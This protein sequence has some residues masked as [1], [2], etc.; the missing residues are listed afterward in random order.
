MDTDYIFG[1]DICE[2]WSWGKTHVFN[3]G[4]MHASHI[5]RG[6]ITGTGICSCMTFFN[7]EV[8][9]A[10]GWKDRLLAKA[11]TYLN[12]KDAEP[13]SNMGQVWYKLKG[14]QE[15]N[16]AMAKAFPE[17]F[18]A[19]P[20]PW[21]LNGCQ[22]MNGVLVETKFK[23][24]N[25]PLNKAWNQAWG[26]EFWGAVHFNCDFS[27][28]KYATTWKVF[29]EAANLYRPEWFNGARQKLNCFRNYPPL[30]VTV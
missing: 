6:Q 23:E 25:M 11:V 26:P 12:V 13:Y 20:K 22:G 17:K 9:R 28:H 18:R 2:L 3:K 7:L 19:T 10:E 24:R 21:S 27:G 15:L 29:R 14:D 30:N 5:A 8:M 16:V 4:Y 1:A